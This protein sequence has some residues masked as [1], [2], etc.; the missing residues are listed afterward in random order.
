MSFVNPLGLFEGQ[1]PEA[2]VLLKNE[3]ATLSLAMTFLCEYTSMWKPVV[4]IP[5]SGYCI[6]HTFRFRDSYSDI[7]SKLSQ[8]DDL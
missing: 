6:H 2:V 4:N 3:I 5:N 7:C 1:G 8:Y